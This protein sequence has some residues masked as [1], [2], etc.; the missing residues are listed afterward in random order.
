M[1]RIFIYF[2]KI[3]GYLAQLLVFRTKIYY[4]DKKV[5]SRRIKG[6]AIV[7][8]NHTSVYDF[9]LYL[10]VFFFRVIRF[11]MAE[12][13][14]KKKLLSLFLKLMGGIKVDRNIHDFS[15]IDK[16]TKHLNKNGVIGIFPESRLPKE[17][18]ETPL[19]FKPSIS[20]LALSSDTKIIPVYTTGGYFK[21]RIKVIIGK[22]IDVSLYYDSSKD[23]KTNINFFTNIL[24]EKIIELR[25]LL[26]EREKK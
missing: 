22:P 16:S 24:R 8:S 3:T 18:E 9:A 6:K 13:L 20:Y 4:E 7:M 17:G 25:D 23:E 2:V 14:F 1:S 12:V 5:Q 15:F 11:Q 26:N 21:K 19:E 10:Y